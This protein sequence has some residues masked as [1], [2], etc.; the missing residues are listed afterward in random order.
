MKDKELIY[1]FDQN[2]N[3][4]IEGLAKM[5]GRTFDEDIL[6]LLKDGRFKLGS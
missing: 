5:S 3:V 4:V 1:I 6:S 2:V